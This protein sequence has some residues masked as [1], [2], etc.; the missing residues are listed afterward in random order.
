VGGLVLSLLLSGCS[1]TEQAGL[2]GSKVPATL[3][4]RIVPSAPDTLLGYGF[5]R[6]ASLEGEYRKVTDNTALVSSGRVFTVERGHVVQ[7][8]VQ[9]AVFKPNVDAGDAGVR[10]QVESSFGGSFI[11]DRVGIFRVRRLERPDLRIFVWFPPERDVMVTMAFRASF[12]DTDR[13]V[14]ALL[15]WEH[16]MPSEGTQLGTVVETRPG[17]TPAP[18]PAASPSASAAAPTPSA[19]P[20]PSEAAP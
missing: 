3:P 11:T 10:A 16:G 17:G 9:V 20:S 5:V 19:S 1:A 15:Y 2:T 4:Q 13:L 8:T 6:Q 7:G 12:T 18:T 14:H